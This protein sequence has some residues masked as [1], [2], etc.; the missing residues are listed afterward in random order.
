MYVIKISHFGYCLL[1]GWFTMLT[2]IDEH[3]TRLSFPNSMD[4]KRFSRARF[5][6]DRWNIASL[7]QIFSKLVLG[8]FFRVGSFCYLFQ[9]YSIFTFSWQIFDKIEKFSLK[10]MKSKGKGLRTDSKKLEDDAPLFPDFKSIDH[11]RVRFCCLLGI[12]HCS[13]F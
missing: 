9:I 12:A 5:C 6:S 7:F 3:V 8:R 1:N 11:S 4:F 2:K 10:K 13:L